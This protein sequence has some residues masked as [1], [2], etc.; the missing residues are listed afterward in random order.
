LLEKG[1]LLPLVPPFMA[2]MKGYEPP[3]KE[4]GTL[5]ESEVARDEEFGRELG[6]RLSSA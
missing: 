3:G 5:Q 4:R 1:G 6:V 2:G